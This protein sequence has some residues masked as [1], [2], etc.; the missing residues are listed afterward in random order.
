MRLHGV[1]CFRS[2]SHTVTPHGDL[3]SQAPPPDITP[4]RLCAP[5][6]HARASDQPDD[7]GD[8]TDGYD[9]DA[10][11]ATTLDGDS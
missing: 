9:D 4:Q 5:A 3:E 1:L 8:D 2:L 11:L 10:L 6:N 7:N